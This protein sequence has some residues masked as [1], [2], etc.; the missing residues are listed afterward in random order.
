MKVA[1][2]L[3]VSSFCGLIEGAPS[4]RVINSATSVFAP[5]YAKLTIYSADYQTFA[6][7]SGTFITRQHIVSSAS[8]LGEA[9]NVVVQFGSSELLELVEKSFYPDIVKHPGFQVGSYEND[10][11]IV[12]L[13]TPITHGER[14]KLKFIFSPA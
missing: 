6:R 12:V 14:I 4:A 10:I 1:V 2:L 8:F 11:A 3:L 5:Y 13:P 9:D 7:G